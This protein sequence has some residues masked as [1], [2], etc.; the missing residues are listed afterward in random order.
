MGPRVLKLRQA[1]D[2]SWRAGPLLIWDGMG[3]SSTATCKHRHTHIHPD[4]NISTFE[5]NLIRMQKVLQRAVH[6]YKVVM[7]LMSWL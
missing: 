2:L 7:T 3:F 6:S 1:G 4:K 5:E